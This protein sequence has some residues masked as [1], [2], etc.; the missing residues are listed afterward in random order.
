MC[1]SMSLSGSMT[2]PGSV[3]GTLNPAHPTPARTLRPPGAV[4]TQT[5]MVSL[6][7]PGE[8]R[9]QLVGPVGSGPARVSQRL[10]I[11]YRPSPSRSTSN[12]SLMIPSSAV[13]AMLSGPATLAGRPPAGGSRSRRSVKPALPVMPVAS[14]LVRLTLKSAVAGLVGCVVL[15]V[16]DTMNSISPAPGGLLTVG[17]ATVSTVAPAGID[18]I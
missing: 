5:P 8:F 12:V 17:S 18:G 9:L 1:Q 14:L 6:W 16:D 15:V 11:S 2:Q 3:G 4:P 7:T 10:S 13:P